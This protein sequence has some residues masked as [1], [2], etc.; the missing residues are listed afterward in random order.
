MLVCTKDVVYLNILLEMVSE[1][2]L[3]VNRHIKFF[4]EKEKGFGGHLYD[5]TAG[6]FTWLSR[7][8]YSY[9]ATALFY[10]HWK[11]NELKNL[12]ENIETKKKSFG[13][14]A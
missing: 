1:L 4:E 14:Y 3:E 13:P 9:R 12:K 7:S 10:T 5:Y 8:G 6:W 2:E 11:E